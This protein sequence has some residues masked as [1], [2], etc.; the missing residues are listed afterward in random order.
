MKL[1][2][3]L[4]ATAGAYNTLLD[5]EELE[6][7]ELDLIRAGYARLAEHARTDL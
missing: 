1:E 6:D 3:L 4:R 5:L 2:E 7:G